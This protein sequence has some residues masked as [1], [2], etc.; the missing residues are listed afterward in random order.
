MASQNEKQLVHVPFALGIDERTQGEHVDVNRFQVLENVRQASAGSASKRYGYTSLGTSRIVSVDSSGTTRSYG[1]KALTV[2][3]APAIIDGTHL[4]VYSEAAAKWST[5][6]RVPHAVT[7]RVKLVSAGGGNVAVCDVAACNGYVVVVYASEASGSETIFVSVVDA[8]NFAPVAPP[9]SVSQYAGSGCRPQAVTVGT[10]VVVL[11]QSAAN[12]LSVSKVNCATAA[13][14]AAYA[15]A[16]VT[17]TT[18]YAGSSSIFTMHALTTKAAVAFMSNASPG[19]V[20]VGTYDLTTVTISATTTTPSNYGVSSPSQLALGGTEADTLWLAIGDGANTV[21]AQARNPST[22]AVT[23]TLSAIGALVNGAYIEWLSVIRTGAATAM[24]VASSDDNGSYGEMQA[25]APG[26]SAGAVTVGYGRYTY[27]CEL[28]SHVW[29]YGSNYYA[30]VRPSDSHD[31]NCIYVARLQ[32]TSSSLAAQHMECVANVAVRLADS[33]A[34]YAALA[35]GTIQAAHTAQLSSTKWIMPIRT[36]K[37]SV[38]TGAE[39][40][41][42]DF[43]HTEQWSAAQTADATHFSSGVPS[44]CDGSRVT[45]INFLHRPPTPTVSLGGTGYTAAT[46][47][48]YIAIYERI[49]AAGNLH[50]SQLSDPVFTGAVANKTMTVTLRCLQFTSQKGPSNDGQTSIALYRTEDAGTTYYRVTEVSNTTA[51][52]VTYADTMSDSTLRTKAQLY[53]QISV[54]G[55]SL[56]RQCP[57]C[58]R[59]LKLHKGCLVGVGDDLTTIWYSAAHVSGEGRWFSDIFQIANEEGGRTYG[60]ASMDGRLYVFKRNRIFVIDGDPPSDNGQVG[61]FGEPIKLPSE[62][63][64]IDGRSIVETPVG[65]FFQ[66]D[67]GIEII[68][69]GQNVTWIGERVQTTLASYPKVTS[70]VTVPARSLVYF[71]CAAAETDASGVSGSGV[72]LVY[73]YA[74]GEWVSVDKVTIGATA[75]AP[76]QSAALATVAGVPTYFRIGASGDSAKEDTATYLDATS[77]WVTQKATTGWLKAG[78]LQG[79]QQ[80]TG[81]SVL[82]SYATDHNLAVAIDYNYVTSLTKTRTYTRAEIASLVSAIGREQLDILGTANDVGMACRITMTDATPTG[83]TVGTGRGATWIGLTLEVAARPGRHKASSGAR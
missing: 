64:C 13:D 10:Q 74:A 46:G 41:V 44:Y 70:A 1:R 16:L 81:G 68:D 40:V 8:T 14:I 80:F 75:S 25:F 72:T 6:G 26:I 58:L 30:L 27:G 22:L 63:G 18:D 11:L 71:T 12:T 57:P 32:T 20:K 48:R 52:T 39:L 60:L 47:V 17:F 7:E 24:V 21:D 76:A 79:I 38:S 19:I 43:G 29:S 35:S 45:E 67:R 73:D 36:I 37:N 56:N 78:G 2:R 54:A 9:V 31:T 50:W 53:R 34:F 65:V 69:R 28:Q 61:G 62:I 5:V 33:G 49:D 51:A 23:G 3:D 82:A 77:T 55:A 42:V 4:D 59:F 66:S 83:G 15:G